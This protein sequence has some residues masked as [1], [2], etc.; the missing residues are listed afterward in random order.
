MPRYIRA[1]VP[2]GSFF[3]T[4]TTLERR[5]SLLTR[6]I[7]ALREVFGRAQRRRPFVID[8]IVVLPDHMHCIW[9]LPPGDADFSARWHEIKAC[10]SARVM[11]GERRSAR[12]RCKGERGIWQRRFWEHVIRDER[13]FERCADYI[14]WNPVKHGHAKS[15][16]DWPH[17]SFHRFVDRGVYTR[18]W[19]AGAIVRALA[20]E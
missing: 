5:R 7:S 13:D 19:A 9:T 14:H 17:S 18:D 15:P 10:F 1:V 3:F 6:N 8:A 20:M 4:V 16:L 11:H 2:G 12:R